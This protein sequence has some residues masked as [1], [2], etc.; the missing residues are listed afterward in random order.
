MFNRVLAICFLFAPRAFGQCPGM[1]FAHLVDGGGWRSSIYLINNSA[2]AKANYILTFRGDT[3]QPVLL[4]FADGRRDNQISGAIAASGVA[5]LETPGSDSDPLTVASATLSITGTLSGF[6]VIRERQAGGPDREATVSL[7]TPAAG[8]L[9][10]PFDNTHGFLSSI[11]L[12]IPCGSDSAITLTATA[13]DEAGAALGKSALKIQG[14]GHSAFMIGDQIPGARDKRGVLR[15]GAP[16]GVYLSGVGLRFTPKGALT[17]FP[18][19]P[20]TPAA[21][22]APVRS[23]HAKRTQLP[24][25]RVP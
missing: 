20:W 3:G 24:V 4:S 19:S 5:I 21:A 11:A 10:F 13:T 25:A 22:H 16:A 6:A 14:G 2:S 17:S 7:A 12:T 9:V 8:G 1:A 15:I 23:Y 18:P